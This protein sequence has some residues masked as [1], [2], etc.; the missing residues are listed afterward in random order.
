M[1]AATLGRVRLRP[2]PQG[3]AFRAHIKGLGWQSG[4]SLA[5]CHLDEPLGAALERLAHED[6]GA[7]AW[8]VLGDP[9]HPF[10]YRF[11][12]VEHPRARV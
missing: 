11:I 6:E 1:G 4:E 10:G 12:L 7:R 8:I 2:T 9:Q 3:P 5:F